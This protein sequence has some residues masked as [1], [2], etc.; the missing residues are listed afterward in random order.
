M[1]STDSL[2]LNA[3]QCRVHAQERGHKVE[4]TGSIP[5]H[6]TLWD[7]I[8]SDHFPNTL[9]ESYIQFLSEAQPYLKI[10]T[11]TTKS[12]PYFITF[13]ESGHS[14]EATKING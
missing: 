9:T 10:V 8:G 5:F 13:I 3:K 6:R 7:K 14:M 2:N 11:R 1:C 4:A 12:K